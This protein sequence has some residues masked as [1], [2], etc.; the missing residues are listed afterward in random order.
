MALGCGIATVLFGASAGAFVIIK[1]LRTETRA[2]AKIAAEQL[3]GPAELI[4]IPLLFWHLD[5]P[6]SRHFILT[7]AG[8]AILS[9]WGLSRLSAFRYVPAF[10]VVLGLI[11]ANQ[12][13]SEAVRPALLRMN[14]AHSRYR[15]A[16]EMYTTFTMAPLGLIWEHHRALNE[17]GHKW[18]VIGD[19]VATSCEANTFILSNNA[20]QLGHVDSFHPE[21][22]GRNA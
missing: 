15:P 6:P 20:E 7:L 18:N 9:G 14:A 10:A 12:I 2:D 19:M 5:P 3:L 22:S 13:L 16:P 21:P 8:F 4:L 1:S 17:R 11:A